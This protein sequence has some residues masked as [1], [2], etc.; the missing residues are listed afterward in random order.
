MDS[1][2]CYKIGFVLKPHGLKG[3]VTI[4]IDTGVPNEISQ[5][6]AV[7]LEIEGRMV[8]YFIDSISIKGDKAF[9]KFEDVETLE[10]ATEI[11]KKRIFLPKSARPKSERGE[12]YDD[13]V[14]GFEVIDQNL[15]LLGKIREVIYAGPNKLLA[16]GDADKEVLIPVNGP[17][18]LSVNKGKKLFTVNLP[19]GFLDI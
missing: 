12:Y 6:D 4:A 1:N 2:D 3:Q 14:V 8:P 19:E 17:F 9:V 18:I 15:G 7:F 13:E 10:A 16:I 5:L 11:A